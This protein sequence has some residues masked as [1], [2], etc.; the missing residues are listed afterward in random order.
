MLRRLGSQQPSVQAQ[1]V[2]LSLSTRGH[3]ARAVTGAVVC[4]SLGLRLGWTAALPVW[5]LLGAAGALL[6]VIDWRTLQL[7]GA[8]VNACLLLA[9]AWIVA[10]SVVTGD[11]HG[12]QRA[13]AGW[14]AGGALFGLIW[15]ASPRSLGYGDVRLAA[16]LGMSLSW[17]DAATPLP[18]LFLA[19]V[20]AAA[21]GLLLRATH[22]L[23]RGQ[24]LPL[25]PF[26]LAG[27]VAAVLHPA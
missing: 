20:L 1:Y 16:L 9:A 14:A 2:A 13:V 7:P 25:G 12:L 8:I 5:V 11:W 23:D 3:L 22:H 24:P 15:L 26:L 27:A 19:L 10:A 18:G 21:A 4:G 17:L 6:A